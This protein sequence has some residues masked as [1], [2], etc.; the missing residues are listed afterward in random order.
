MSTHVVRGGS[1][2][3]RWS[4]LDPSDT[5]RFHRKSIFSIRVRLRKISIHTGED[6]E[7]HSDGVHWNWTRL[8]SLEKYIF[9]A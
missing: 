7:N 5:N 1:K 6:V 3:F 2:S 4:P 8:D 9:Y